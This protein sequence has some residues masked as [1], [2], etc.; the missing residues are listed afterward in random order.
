MK[1]VY[2]AQQW[3]LSGAIGLPSKCLL[4]AHRR[5]EVASTTLTSVCGIFVLFTNP[6]EY[7]SFITINQMPV[8]NEDGEW[9]VEVEWIY[10][11]VD[12]QRWSVIIG[13]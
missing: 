10:P 3:K 8:D 6:R 9:I 7:S 2:R 5:Q 12:S 4:S 1:E 13:Q 11:L